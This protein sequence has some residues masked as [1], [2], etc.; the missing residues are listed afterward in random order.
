[1]NYE[2]C[3]CFVKTYEQIQEEFALDLVLSNV[4][5][6]IPLLKLI[7][8]HRIECNLMLKMSSAFCD[9]VIS[10]VHFILVVLVRSLI[11]DYKIQP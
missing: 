6:A 5:L 10:F 11:P 2:K 1:M 8:A 3:T 9:A 4:K 7:S